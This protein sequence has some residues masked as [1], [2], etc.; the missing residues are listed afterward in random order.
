MSVI[1]LGDGTLTS[2]IA[3]DVSP[4]TL[5]T[6][7]LTPDVMGDNVDVIEGDGGWAVAYEKGIYRRVFPYRFTLLT[8]T[9]RDS[10]WQWWQKIKGRLHWFT[11]QPHGQAI[12]SS[13]AQQ[14]VGGSNEYIRNSLLNQTTPYWRGFWVMVLD[15]A[16]QGQKRKA[17]HST[18]TLG[19]IQV[20]P[21]FDNIVAAGNMVLLGYP[22]TLDED[23][24]NFAPRLPNFWDMQIIFREKV[25]S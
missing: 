15:G 22:V 2:S 10:I 12:T 8:Q 4:L 20:S 17:I 19:D 18:G 11:L 13:I 23:S 5:P 7:A 3:F 6:P 9:Q 14:W 25:M 16:A 21:V 1:L 24:I